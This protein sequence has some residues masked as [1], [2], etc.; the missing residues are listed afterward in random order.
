MKRETLARVATGAAVA[1]AAVIGGYM[2]VVRPWHV[3]WG[4]T[5]AEV[6]ERLPGDEVVPDAELE[7]THAVTIEAPVTAVWPWLAQVGQGRAGFYSYSW[8][9]NLVGCEMENADRI[10]PEWQELRVGDTVRLHPKVPPLPVLI[11]EPYRA[12]VMGGGADEAGDGCNPTTGT[13]GFYL[14]AVDE[15]TSRLLMRCRWKRMPGL[16]SWL[17]NYALLEPAHFVMERKMLLGIKARAEALA[18][19]QD[20]TG[21]ARAENETSLLPSV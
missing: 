15:K 7:A 21:P 10:V 8:L 6:R 4:A 11:V 12:I 14:K 20:A 19:D 13:W 1:G 5:D 2:G 18:R 9:E 17:C 16:L 3:R